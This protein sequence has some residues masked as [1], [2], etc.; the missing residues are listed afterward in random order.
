MEEQPVL[1]L[2]IDGWPHLL[3]TI[4]IMALSLTAAIAM[5]RQL[6]RLLPLRKS[7][8][9]R[10]C[11]VLVFTFSSGG[12]LWI[13]D[14]N[15]LYLLPFFFA[16]FL[17][18]CQGILL[19]RLTMA[20]VFYSLYVSVGMLVDSM[21]RLAALTPP[22][23]G[24]A[25]DLLKLVFWTAI[26]LVI[27]RIAPKGHAVTLS[28]RLW[29]LMGM[30]A[31]APLFAQL[32]FVLGLGDWYVLGDQAAAVVLRIAYLTLPFV[33]LSDL[34]LL[35]ALV[36]LS[37]Y[38][39]L[40]LEQQVAQLGRSYYEQLEQQQFQVRRLRHDMIHH[41]ETLS[42]LPA[43]E[44]D[45][46]LAQILESPALKPARRYCQHHVANVVLAAKAAQ[47][48]QMG[49]ALELEVAL[50][51][52]LPFA[53]VDLCA[54]LSN[55]LDNALEACAKLPASQ[56]RICLRAKADKGMLAIRMEN[57]CLEP[58]KVAGKR[59]L[60]SKPDPEG[61][62][63]GTESI[64]SIV[65]KYGGSVTFTQQQDRFEV[66]LWLPLNTP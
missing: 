40:S 54:L 9:L 55:A 23:Y 15:A 60:S 20:A 49:T 64:R 36:T 63:F 61:H 2:G 48:E 21:E 19:A 30:L 41:L 12:P 39:Q 18:C 16:A 11:M 34:A 58:A 14:G 1:F 24:F 29:T 8:F 50:P 5:C 6:G 38:E 45:A 66:L 42:A 28:R 65:Q 57:P 47:A 35:Y 7:W 56:R 31:L 62:G 27:R 10:L 46:Y 33:A 4:S 3:V 59:L 53:D 17:V 22:F 26:L 25:Q 37:R 51:E 13:G 44:K 52:K 32:A 43:E